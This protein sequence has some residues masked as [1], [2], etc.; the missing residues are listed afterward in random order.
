MCVHARVCS[1]SF[2]GE[3]AS[4]QSDEVKAAVLLS[5]LVEVCAHACSV[6]M[7]VCVCV[8]VCVCLCVY[9]C[10]RARARRRAVSVRV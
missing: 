10:V 6:C 5:E 9:V 2:E 1:Y 7:C 3:W 4:L 8:C